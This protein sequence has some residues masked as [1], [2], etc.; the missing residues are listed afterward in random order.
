[1]KYLNFYFDSGSVPSFKSDYSID[2]CRNQLKNFD[3][4]TAIKVEKF[5]DESPF[6]YYCIDLKGDD[7]KLRNGHG[8]PDSN[9]VRIR[10]L[11]CNYKENNPRNTNCKL[12]KGEDFPQEM[13]MFMIIW[14]TFLDTT[15]YE[16]PLNYYSKVESN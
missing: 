3:E 10:I 4:D 13:Y 8:T 14:D 16:N 5:I 2:T 11:P 1:M 15:Q 12:K 9:N 7:L 6:L